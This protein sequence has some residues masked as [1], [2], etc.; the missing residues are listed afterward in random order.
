VRTVRS[1]LRLGA[2]P[3]AV[4]RRPPR[5]GEHSDE[6]RRWLETAERRSSPV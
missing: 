4:S 2:T 1:P 3:A 5:L 6:I